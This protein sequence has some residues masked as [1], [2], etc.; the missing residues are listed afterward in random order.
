MST[1]NDKHKVNIFELLGKISTK[2]R[3][4]YQNLTEEEQKSIAPYVIM[5]WLSGTQN[6]QQIYLLNEV[7]N[8]YV[9]DLAKHKDLLMMLLTI[10]TSGKSQRYKW[11]KT[12]SKSGSIPHVVEV[13]KEYYN[14]STR[15]AVDIIPLLKDDDIILYAEE[16]GRQPSEITQIKKELKTR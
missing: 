2:Q 5:R 4:Y 1:Q 9:F 13:V 3:E 15:H 8:P 6:A 16:L 12:K 11:M 14:Y 7:V 10:C